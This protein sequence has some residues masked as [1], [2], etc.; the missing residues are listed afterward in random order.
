MAFE[1]TCPICGDRSGWTI[2]YR[3]DPRVDRWRAEI[4]DTA[5]YRWRLC[6]HC[7][8]GHPSSSPDL[9][10]LQRLWD[11]NRTTD[12][13]DGRSAETIWAFRRAIAKRG[14][15][16]S[17]HLFAPLAARPKGRFLDIACGLGQTVRTFADHGWDA[18]GIDADPNTQ[19]FHRELG[20]KSR[21]GQ[22]ETLETNGNYDIIHIAHGIY[23]IS[24]PMGFLR[25]VR[26]RL[27]PGGL[28]CIVLADFMAHAD[29][30]LPA[31]ELTFFPT[32]SSMQ[33][34]LAL[35]GFET[36][37]CRRMSGS[38]FIAARPAENV[39]PPRVWPRGILLLYRTKMLRHVLIGRPYIYMRQTAKTFVDLAT[40]SLG[41]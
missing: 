27:A 25:G 23:F 20:I 13:G 29:A 37:F 15:D 31:Y 7:G 12:T 1:M 33:F 38:I 30:G 17:Y 32:R 3:H 11:V 39:P 22:F 10:I 9:R 18:E 21:I 19:R 34:A 2:T 36:V 35:A 14:A 40:S 4:G 16:R 8:N 6:A 26:K 41:R 5:S 28:L 24:D